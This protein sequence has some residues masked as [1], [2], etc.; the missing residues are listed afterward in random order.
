MQT[1]CKTLGA[2]LLGLGMLSQEAEAE[3][4]YNAVKSSVAVY[5]PKNIG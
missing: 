1:L 4:M 2:G 5:N 3:S